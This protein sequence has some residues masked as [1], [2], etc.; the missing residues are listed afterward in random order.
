MPELEEE[1]SSRELA[2]KGSPFSQ[3][4][5]KTLF[6]WGHANYT[7]KKER[8]VIERV[9]EILQRNDFLGVSEG[10]SSLYSDSVKI[11][12]RESLSGLQS[13]VMLSFKRGALS[14]AADLCINVE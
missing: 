11:Y 1:E 9:L 13:M 8:E 3:A 14:H 4:N 2:L 6:D 10:V 12:K 5:L 7:R